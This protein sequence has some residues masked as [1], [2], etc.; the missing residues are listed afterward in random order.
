MIR[1]DSHGPANQSCSHLLWRGTEFI[2][3]RLGADELKIAPPF[4]ARTAGFFLSHPV[5]C[6]QSLVTACI[7][8]RSQALPGN[9]L[10]RRLRLGRQSR[11]DQES[12]SP[13]NA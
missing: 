6:H 9:A 1:L 11:A 7:S 2:P 12:T 13:D 3:F 8:P 5:I 4:L 10:C